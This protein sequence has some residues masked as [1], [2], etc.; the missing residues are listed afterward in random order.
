MVA[1]SID[2]G[3]VGFSTNRFVPHVLPD[4]RSIPGTFAEKE[5]LIEIAKAIAPRKALMQNVLN[6]DERDFSTELLRDLARTTQSRV[7]FSFGVSRNPASGRRAREY[8]DSLCERG[9]DITAIS[10]PRS[11]GFLFGLQAMLPVKGATWDALRKKNLAA[12]L[13]AIE[14][15]E[16]CRN[17]IAESQEESTVRFPIEH[18][19][20]MGSG[21]VP[22]YTADNDQHLRTMA[23]AAGEHW[24]ETFLRLSRETEGRGLFTLRIFNRSI[25]ALEELFRSDQAFPALGDAGAHVSQIMDAGW[26]TFVLSHWVRDRGLYSMGEGIRRITSAPAK[27]I[28][29]KDRGLLAP[30][31]KADV[32]VFD[33]DRVTELQPELVHDFPGDAPRFIQRSAGYKTTLVNGQVS[34]IDGEHV[35]VRA[36]GVLRHAH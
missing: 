36:G 27:V 23:D 17:L 28:G 24:C 3:A 22:Q 1:Q 33:A 13:A 19:F 11:S 5:E 34:V 10:Q 32:N 25:E 9:L 29:L 2:D 21:P 15:G 30:G 6:F 12:R 20:W 35:G 31:F 26:A 7:L 8:V 16:V 18:M 14:D 4:G